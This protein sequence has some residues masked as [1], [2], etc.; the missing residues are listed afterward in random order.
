M[1]DFTKAKRFDDVNDQDVARGIP[2]R[3]YR[4]ALFSAFIEEW[5]RENPSRAITIMDSLVARIP[6]KSVKWTDRWYLGFASQYAIAR[7]PDKARALLDLYRADIKDS[8]VLRDNEPDLHN[9]L[10]EIAL[11]EKRPLEALAEFRLQDRGRTVPCTSVLR[12]NFLTSVAH[13]ISRT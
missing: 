1:A 12:A 11:A 4:H 7:R 2:L 8:S 10:G 6:F 3:P 5:W 9:A 13:T